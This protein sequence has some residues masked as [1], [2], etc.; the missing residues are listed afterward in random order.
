MTGIVWALLGAAIAVVLSGIGS[1]VGVGR[2]GQAS[3]GLL[4]KDPTKFGSVLL[5]QL[6]PATQGLYGF[7]IGFMVFIQTGIMGSAV[8]LTKEAGLAYFMLCLPIAL[9]GLGSAIMQSAV[10]IGGINL[11][12]KQD[13]QMGHAMTMAVLVE[14]FAIFAFIISFLGV[15]MIGKYFGL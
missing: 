5:L 12:G 13:K 1:A 8:V 9:V 6:L 4:S 3:A 2:A 15:M 11:V 14:I 10:A 7:V